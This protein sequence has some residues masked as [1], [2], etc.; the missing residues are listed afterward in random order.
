M[1]R[2][3]KIYTL[4]DG[5]TTAQ[6]FAVLGSV[7]KFKRHKHAWQVWRTLKEFGCKVYPVAAG[8]KRL[9]GF[10]FYAGLM[11]LEGKVDVVVPCLLP[12]DAPTLVEDAMAAGAKFIWFQEQTWAPEFE[13][14]CQE[15]GIIPIQGC[16]LKHKIYRKPWGFMHPCYWH[17]LHA[18][19]AVSR[20][21]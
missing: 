13:D 11:E 10:K 1:A 2:E 3:K 4:A 7:E 12:P 18:D 16:V 17:G 15:A 21:F 5:L 8:I 9:D 6:S 14:K 19:K 20:K